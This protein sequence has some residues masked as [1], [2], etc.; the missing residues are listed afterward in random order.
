MSQAARISYSASNSAQFQKYLAF[1]LSF[2]MDKTLGT[3]V[4]IRASQMNGCAFCVD[5]HVKQ[6]TIEGERALRLHHVAIWRES[7]LFSARERAALEWTEALTQI[8]KEGVS[9]SLY[10]RVRAQFSEEE[11][12]ELTFRVTAI[13]GWNRMNV[14]FRT[15]PGILDKQYGLDRAG[16]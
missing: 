5:M 8:D 11:L 9:D 12:V 14:A 6:A 13:N 3:L 15:P 10:D 2:T 16:L 4:D 1:A 7:N